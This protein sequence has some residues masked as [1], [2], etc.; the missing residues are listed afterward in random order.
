MQVLLWECNK[1]LN[2]ALLDF[3][4][5]HFEVVAIVCMIWYF[6]YGSLETLI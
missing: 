4:F 1:P 6:N 5:L 2:N 3:Y